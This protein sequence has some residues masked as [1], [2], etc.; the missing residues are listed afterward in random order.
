MKRAIVNYFKGLFL[1]LLVIATIVI[2]YAYSE[3]AAVHYGDNPIGMQWDKEGPYVFFEDEDSISVNYIHGHWDEGLHSEK[4]QVSLAESPTL[5]TFF[6]LDKS[7]FSFQLKSEFTPPPTN[8]NDGNKILAI[9]DIESGYKAFRDL[10]IS[11][12]VIDN[13]LNWKFGQNHLVLVGDFV[14]RGKSTT[15]VLWFIYKLEQDA[16]RHGGVVHFIIGN[17]EIK[18]MQGDFKAASPKYYYLAA[19]LEKAQIELFGHNSFLGRWI[20]SKN[21]MEVINGHLFVH[22]GI[23]PDLAE[24]QLTLESAN[25]LIRDNY[26]RPYYPGQAEGDKKI[27]LSPSSGPSWY[28]GYFKEDLTQK[29]VEQGLAKFGAEAVVVGHT[30][31]PQINRQFQG[32]VIAIDVAHPNDYNLYWPAR[33]SQALLIDGDQYFRLLE[34]G[35]QEAI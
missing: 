20:A 34:D 3:N 18:N 13:Q 14:D 17:H 32:K 12:S 16:K 5:S 7:E 6:P 28:R 1:T 19:V 9:S 4:M 11:H 27:L 29:A 24:S 26:R 31:Q 23:H 2:I 25:Q 8:Y 35:S 22:G 15:Q 21:T 33:E 10:L 30:L